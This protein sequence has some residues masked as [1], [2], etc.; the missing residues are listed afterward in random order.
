MLRPGFNES[1]FVSKSTEC[2]HYKYW[3]SG[4]HKR[5]K[6][7]NST[8]ERDRKNKKERMNIG[9]IKYNRRSFRERRIRVGYLGSPRRVRHVVEN[10]LGPLPQTTRAHHS[11]PR[12][13]S[14]L[15]LPSRLACTR[16][17]LAL[18]TRHPDRSLT[19]Q[20]R[21]HARMQSFLGARL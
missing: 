5:L 3:C 7:E 17:R 18:P 8:C 6:I 2:P 19:P 14:T 4:Q 20:G 13:D 21:R 16:F 11:W 12:Y 9:F 10:H 1:S 15:S